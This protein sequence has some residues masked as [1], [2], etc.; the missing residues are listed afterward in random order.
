MRLLLRVPKRQVRIAGLASLLV[1]M[2]AGAGVMAQTPEPTDQDAS[3]SAA[4]PSAVSQPAPAGLSPATTSRVPAVPYDDSMP[5]SQHPEEQLALPSRADEGLQGEQE[6][7]QGEQ[8]QGEAQEQGEATTQDPPPAAAG[9][10]LL[11]PEERAALALVEDI[12]REQEGILMGSGFDYNSGGRRDPFRSLVPNS[13]VEAPTVRPFGLPGF[14][15]S[16]VDLKAI[17]TARG[18]WH[19][20]VTGPNQR[21]YFLEVGTQLYDGHVVDIRPGEVVFE[22]QV[23]DL[24]GARRSRS[25]TKRLRTTD[26]GG[27]QTP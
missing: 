7:A 8:A 18:R 14:L 12:I 4:S 13:S 1:V 9:L 5:S 24:M 23:P 16:E 3:R 11:S 2:G 22:Q 19:A 15:I 27:G 20:M 26:S 17:A 25:V 21:A 10:E 6:Q